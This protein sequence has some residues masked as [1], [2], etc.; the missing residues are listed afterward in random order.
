MSKKPIELPGMAASLARQLRVRTA[1]LHRKA[2]RTGIMHELAH[3]RASLAGYTLLL[4]NLWPA[5]F[6]LESALERHSAAPG[7]GRFARPILYRA[8][9]IAQDLA[10]LSGPDWADR[11]PLLEAGKAYAA[12]V[13]AAAAGGGERLIAHA[14]TRYLGDLNGGQA[15]RAILSESAGLG[16]GKNAFYVFAGDSP[17]DGLKAEF[18]LDLDRAGGEIA[19]VP[20]VIEEALHAFE[21]NIALSC[22]VHDAQ[23]AVAG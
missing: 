23:R 4:R 16:P 9:A 6:E 19:S 15:I 5:Y 20:A 7:V 11:I 21:C 10:A 22:A 8:P 3:R 12:R 1:G 14:Y 18:R 13:A 17:L 2:Q